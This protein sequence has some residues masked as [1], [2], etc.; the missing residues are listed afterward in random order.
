MFLIKNCIIFFE[1]LLRSSLYSGD[2]SCA[3]Y[4][5]HFGAQFSKA[6][7]QRLLSSD[8]SLMVNLESNRLERRLVLMPSSSLTAIP[9]STVAPSPLAVSTCGSLSS[10]V[11]TKAAVST[12]K[13]LVHTSSH[14]SR[15]TVTVSSSS[16]PSL[17]LSTSGTVTVTAAVAASVSTPVTSSSF[18]DGRSSS[19]KHSNRMQAIDNIAPVATIGTKGPRQLYVVR[20][21]ERIDFT[22]G[23]DWIQ[24][25]FNQAGY[26]NL[27]M[28]A[29]QF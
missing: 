12:T 19:P 7:S 28:A 13:P 22:F 15:P 21:G 1:Q 18:Q 5:N 8:P 29:K 26:L 10:A 2:H 23:K 25:S 11:M 3:T 16:H 27:T 14:A 20:H 4:V 17:P 24:N 6:A 9:E